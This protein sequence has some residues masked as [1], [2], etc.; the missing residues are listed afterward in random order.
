MIDFSLLIDLL[1]FSGVVGYLGG[2]IFFPSAF[3][4]SEEQL[5]ESFV[6]K[7]SLAGQHVVPKT[8]SNR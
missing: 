2:L 8:V 5:K 6:I 4:S 3:L 1:A 7:R